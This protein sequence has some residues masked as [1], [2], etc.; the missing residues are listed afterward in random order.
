MKFMFQ[1]TLYH[2]LTNTP[3]DSGINSDSDLPREWKSKKREHSNT[4]SQ[5][6]LKEKHIAQAPILVI[7][8]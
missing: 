2:M 5:V 6:L 4:Q 1:N 3:L 7:E 8:H